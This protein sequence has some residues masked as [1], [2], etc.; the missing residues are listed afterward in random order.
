[1]SEV[2][3]SEGDTEYICLLKAQR[4]WMYKEESSEPFEDWLERNHRA[5]LTL[6]SGDYF[7]IS[8]PTVYF[9]NPA[10]KTLFLLKW[11]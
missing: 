6:G 4:Y 2:W 3:I 10:D 7:Q 11:S 1:M 8:N 9:L 5:F